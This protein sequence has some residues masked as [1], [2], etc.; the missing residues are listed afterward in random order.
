MKIELFY[1]PGCDKCAANRESLKAAAKR[2]VPSLEWRE[3][4]VLENMDYAVDLGV[5]A[6][7]AL[8][9]DGVLEF[10]ALPSVKQL[11]DVIN[12]KSTVLER[13]PHGR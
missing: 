5:L 1:A 2:A 10:P 7:P 6:L 11:V 9:I 8:A 3:L 12:R 4:D 13:P